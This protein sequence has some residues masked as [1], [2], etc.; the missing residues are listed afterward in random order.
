[1]DAAGRHRHQLVEAGPVLLEEHAVLEPHRV[2]V[3]AAD[4]VVA[5]HGGGISLQLADHGA[6]MA[7]VDAGQ[8]V[9]PAPD[10]PVIEMIGCLRDINAL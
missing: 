3:L 2:V 1:M 9:V 5:A 6:G 4:V 8:P 10:E 7:V